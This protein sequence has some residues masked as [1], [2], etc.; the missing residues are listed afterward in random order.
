MDTR[1][2]PHLGFGFCAAGGER[3]YYTLDPLGNLRPCNHT[4]TILGNLF[5]QSFA[6]LIATDRMAEFVGAIPQFCDPCSQRQICQGGC[7]ASA[8]VCYG[9]LTAEDPF[10]NLGRERALRC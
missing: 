9:S 7:R 4:P 2:F 5:H 3:A 1:A 8:Q 6:E 10:L